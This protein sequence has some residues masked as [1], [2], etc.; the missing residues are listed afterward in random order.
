MHVNIED[1]NKKDS[2]WMK[3]Y[4]LCCERLRIQDLSEHA[5]QPLHNED[6]T[7][8]VILNGE[9]YNF[10]ELRNR[11]KRETSIFH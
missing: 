7:I 9:I 2:M 10:Q 6:E 4:H 5:K 11:I 8:W 3:K 1:L